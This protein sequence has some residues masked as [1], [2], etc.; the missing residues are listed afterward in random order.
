MYGGNRRVSG[1]RRKEV[2]MLAGVSVD[3]YIRMERGNAR[4]A[5]TAFSRTSPAPCTSTRPSAPTSTISRARR[6]TAPARRRRPARQQVRPA[7]Q[8]LLDAMTMAPAY[9]RNGRMD[10]LAATGSDAPCSRRCSAAPPSPR[11]WPGS[12]SLTRPRRRSTR[13]GIAWP[14]TPSRLLRAE[15]GRNPTDR[16]PVRPDRRALHPQRHLPHPLGRPRRAPAPL[17]NQALPPPGRRR[18]QP[19]LRSRSNSSPTPAWSSTATAPSR[20]R[21]RGRAEP[22]RQLGGH[23]RSGTARALGQRCD[24]G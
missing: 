2:A 3:Y 7:V 9:V 13:N 14:A 6:T 16:G 22:A 21:F 17:R 24:Q 5:P 12:F 15:A 8:R 18:H 20:H 23:D 11:T 1:L 19:G 4:G 10:V